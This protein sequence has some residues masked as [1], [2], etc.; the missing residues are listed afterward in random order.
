VRPFAN[1]LDFFANK[2]ARLRAWRL[3]L[4]LTFR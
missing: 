3:P 1:Q 2:L 4:A